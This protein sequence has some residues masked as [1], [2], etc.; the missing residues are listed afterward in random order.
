MGA[1]ARVKTRGIDKEQVQ[2]R[3]RGVPPN[4]Q[5]IIDTICSMHDPI[6]AAKSLET[7]TALLGQQ[8][9]VLL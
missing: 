6:A 4:M 5:A 1:T 9:Q 8:S 3:P 2:E 7:A